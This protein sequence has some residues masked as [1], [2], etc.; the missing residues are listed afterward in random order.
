M[1]HHGCD[2]CRRVKP[3]PHCKAAAIWRKRWWWCGYGWPVALENVWRVVDLVPACAN[4]ETQGCSAVCR[5]NV[6]TCTTAIA[7]IQSA[8]I[9]WCEGIDIVG[10]RT[11]LVHIAVCP[12]WYV[13]RMTDACQALAMLATPEQQSSMHGVY[14]ALMISAFATWH[15][16]VSVPT[17]P[18][19]S[20]LYSLT[21][22]GVRLKSASLLLCQ[23]PALEVPPC[24]RAHSST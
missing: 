19:P 6:K 10:A 18:C 16:R 8:W 13:Q 22:R 21:P 23:N 20:H 15:S 11:T 12:H 7:A 2:L 3:I 4:S 1:Q 9:S 17:I 5:R 24:S 14:V